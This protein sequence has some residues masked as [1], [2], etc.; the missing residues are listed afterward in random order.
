MLVRGTG[1]LLAWCLQEVSLWIQVGQACIPDAASKAGGAVVAGP[2]VLQVLSVRDIT[3]PEKGVGGDG[4]K[5]MMFLLLTDG[6]SNCRCL[7]YKPVG[8]LSEAMAPGTKVLIKNA[9]VKLGIILLDPRSIQVGPSMK[10]Y[11]SVL[12]QCISFVSVPNQL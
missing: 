10:G 5:R 11:W 4:H 6:R 1:L 8:D 3:R 12:V 9:A 2:I 7:E